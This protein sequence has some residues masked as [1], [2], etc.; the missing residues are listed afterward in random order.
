MRSTRNEYRSKTILR[1]NRHESIFNAPPPLPKLMVAKSQESTTALRVP[2]IHFPSSG[3]EADDATERI[4]TSV[5]A[6]DAFGNLILLFNAT[7]RNQD[8]N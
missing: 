2:S 1:A 6:N 4:G 5:T 7:N 8:E 3:I